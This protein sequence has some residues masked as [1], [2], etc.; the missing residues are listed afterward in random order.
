MV[1][2]VVNQTFKL[3]FFLKEVPVFTE[4]SR[5]N[6][7]EKGSFTFLSS[8][9]NMDAF[10]LA[11]PKTSNMFGSKRCYL[12]GLFSSVKWK[13]DNNELDGMPTATSNQT[14]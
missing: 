12:S 9:F 13:G 3:F 14:E 5:E 4:L 10:V 11:L 2:A 8:F 7:E 1:N 6:D